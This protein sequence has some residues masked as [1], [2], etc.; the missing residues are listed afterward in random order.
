MARN[1][2]TLKQLRAFLLV[3]DKGSFVGASEA[4]A[5]SQPATTQS[6][7]QLEEQLGS[8]LFHRTTR[9]V[10]L[11]TVGLSL[12]PIARQLLGQF[13][14]AIADVQDAAARKQ[15]RVVVACLPS[16]AYR[17]MPTVIANRVARPGP[18]VVV[19]DVNLKAI[20]AAVVEGQADIG[21]GSFETDS[22][23]LDSTIIAR[24]RFYAVIPKRYARRGDAEVR[25]AD[26]QA[27]PFIAMTS[28]H[29][30]RELVDNVATPQGLRLRIASEVSNLATIYGLLEEGV[31]VTVLPGLALPP[32]DH[33]TLVYRPLVDPVLKR[34]IRVVWRHGV[35]LSSGSRALIR[36]MGNA[37]AEGRILNDGERVEWSAQAMT[38]LA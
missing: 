32:G 6:I 36:A 13:D 29:G 34:T 24:D 4:L 37:V 16:I 10:K 33:P 35:G 19:R 27:M 25:W 21:I 12:L 1:N 18:R 2:V 30:I 3:A 17:I 15:G 11:S 22:P 26:L 23:A 8:Q 9:S 28:E 5:L 20:V 14:T 7:Q 31:G 38:H